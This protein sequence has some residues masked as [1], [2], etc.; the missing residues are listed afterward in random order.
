MEII[1]SP[2][3]PHP[4]DASADIHIEAPKRRRTNVTHSGLLCSYAVFAKGEATG[5][6]AELEQD[7]SPNVGDGS[8]V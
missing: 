7:S 5:S 6:D 4:D 3:C 8:Q 2:D 1:G